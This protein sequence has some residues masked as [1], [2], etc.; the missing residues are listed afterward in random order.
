[1]FSGIIVVS[2]SFTCVLY[3]P[4]YRSSTLLHP[5][6]ADQWPISSA[7]SLTLGF[8]AVDSLQMR[9]YYCCNFQGGEPVQQ[10]RSDQISSELPKRS[11]LLMLLTSMTLEMC[12]SFC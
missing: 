7:E 9:S 10:D 3:S 4:A 6:Q 2:G 5:H 11:D 12:Q 1:M 8:L